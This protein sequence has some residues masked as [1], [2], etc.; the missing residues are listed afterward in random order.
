[1][2]QYYYAVILDSEGK[3]V[4]WMNAHM[5]NSGLKLMEHSYLDSLFVNTFEFCLTQDGPYHKSRVVWAGDYADKEPG[6]ETNLYHQCNE[7]SLISPVN[8]SA[9]I[10][11]YIINHTKM[12]YVDKR[13]IQSLHPLPLLTA[14]GNGRGGGDIYDAPSFVGSWARDVISVEEMLPEGFEEIVFVLPPEE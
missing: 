7:S 13:K 11:P 2:G 8:R 1:M 5:Y 10:Y 3:I 9:A 12:Q 14:E 4:A 6:Q